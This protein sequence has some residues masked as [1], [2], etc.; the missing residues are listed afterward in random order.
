MNLE[1]IINLFGTLVGLATVA[2]VVQSPNTARIIQASTSGFTSSVRA[3]MG[4]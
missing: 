1:R 2:V 3:A 4:R